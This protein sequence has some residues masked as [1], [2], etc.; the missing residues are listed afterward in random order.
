[1]DWTGC[2]YVVNNECILHTYNANILILYEQ[3]SY[4]LKVGHK[5]ER[6]QG[7]VWDSLKGRKGK[8]VITL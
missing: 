6:K 7:G 2:I 4:C 8:D 5:L 3:Y 1:M